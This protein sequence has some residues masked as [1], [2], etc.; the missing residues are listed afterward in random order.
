[1]SPTAIYV[2]KKLAKAFVAFI[3]LLFLVLNIASS[4]FLPTSYFS[5]VEGDKAAAVQLLRAVKLLPEFT[6]LIDRQRQIYGSNLDNELFSSEKNREV[7]I[8]RMEQLVLQYP[9]SRD[10][11][12]GLYLLY[13]DEGNA[14]K[15]NSYLKRA[16]QIDPT[17]GKN[18]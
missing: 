18:F 6:T 9:K 10:I 17:V 13:S 1:M 12:Y 14:E 16:Q 11:L 2:L 4:Q 5:F 8:V 7:K 15:A 3:F